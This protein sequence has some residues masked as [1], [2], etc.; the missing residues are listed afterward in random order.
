VINKLLLTFAARSVLK[1]VLDNLNESNGVIE[2]IILQMGGAV[3]MLAML[4]F[5]R[6][7]EAQ[8]DLL[9]FY[10]TLRAGWDPHGFLKLFDHL[11]ELEKSSGGTPAP[12]LSDH[13]PTPERA[14]AI[15]REL[16][17]VS[18]PAGA[19]SDSVKFEIFKTAMGL[20]PEPAEKTASSEPQN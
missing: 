3:A 2:K 12:F 17:L 14:A 7:D 4:H 10:E 13:P 15:R 5:S 20:L 8:A 9:G 6:T 1:P 16:R 11:D 19:T 18:V